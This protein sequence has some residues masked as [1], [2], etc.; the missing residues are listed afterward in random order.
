MR[1]VTNGVLS[2]RDR[3][4]KYTVAEYYNEMMLFISEQEKIKADINK[5]KAG[6]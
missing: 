3:L 1:A 6:K 4:L 5:T 2:E